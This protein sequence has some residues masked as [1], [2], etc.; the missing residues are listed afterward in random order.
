MKYILTIEQ[1][2]NNLV[3]LWL[4][5][6]RGGFIKRRRYDSMHYN[7]H[8]CIY[9][10]KR[11]CSFVNVENEGFQQLMKTVARLYTLPSRKTITKL[12]DLKYKILKS[13]F[14]N[15]IKDVSSFTITCDIW[16]DISNKSCLGI[17]VHL[18]KNGNVTY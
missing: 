13:K 10:C 3:Y 14:I 4:F 16:T 1:I 11:Q 15:N 9:D 18:F 8:S 12:L 17:T 5:I 6:K 7:K 2:N